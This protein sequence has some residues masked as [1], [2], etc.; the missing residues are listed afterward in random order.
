MLRLIDSDEE[1]G[2]S[3]LPQESLGEEVSALREALGIVMTQLRS[4]GVDVPKLCGTTARLCDSITRTVLAQQKLAAANSGIE[5][6]RE[7]ID[8]IWRAIGWGEEEE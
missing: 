6:T 3:D 1:H 8:R 4:G 5:R 7:R 2:L